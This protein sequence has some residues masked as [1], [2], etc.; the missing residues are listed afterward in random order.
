MCIRDRFATAG[1]VSLAQ[2]LARHVEL[3]QFVTAARMSEALTQ[4]LLEDDRAAS[5][6][7]DRVFGDFDS[8]IAPTSQEVGLY[9]AA[10]RRAVKRKEK[11]S[12]ERISRIAD[13][14]PDENT[15]VPLLAAHQGNDGTQLV[16]ILAKLGAPYDK[17]QTAGEEGDVPAGDAA[18]TLF[19]RLAAT[20]RV[21][22]VKKRTRF[23]V[24]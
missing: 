4:G 20:D 7:H 23:R 19:N 5:E 14:A 13:F 21:Q 22:L 16:A 9:R 10:A 2:A 11:L 17:L 8:F 12:L 18:G 6:L 1:W 24:L 3:R 15:V